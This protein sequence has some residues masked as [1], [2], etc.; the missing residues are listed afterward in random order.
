MQE[1][2]DEAGTERHVVV[3]GQQRIRAVLSFLAGDFV[4]SDESPVAPGLEF[5]EL[6]PAQRKKLF[7]Y[8][9]V[10]RQLPDMPDEEIRA[11]FQRINR[12]TVTL[13]P[14]ELRHA[15]YWG[16]FIKLME[17]LADAE[18][19]ETFATF[20]ANDRRRMIDIEFISE[21]TIA[22]LNG[23]QN[24][25]RTLEEFYQ[26]YETE[27]D[28]APLVQSVFMAVLG[29]LAQVLPG[30]AKTRWRKKSDFY[31]LFLAFS[32]HAAKLPLSA[33]SRAKAGAALVALGAEV[34]ALISEA[35]EQRDASEASRKYLRGVERA[36]SDLANRKAR[37]VVLDELLLPTFSNA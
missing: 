8:S 37:E 19:W 7:E 32:K 27:F 16:P 21:L 2:V 25:K 36:A 33:E 9:F 14:Q 5:D 3:D 13:N 35:M 12:N 22:H 23:P 26:Q 29:E 11:I 1:F 30:L 18:Q 28:D 24:K 17:A 31:S 15:T 4:L 34:D 6:T 20:S 10:V